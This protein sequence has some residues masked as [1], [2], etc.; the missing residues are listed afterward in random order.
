MLNSTHDVSQQK[1]VTYA[2][3]AENLFN[4]ADDDQDELIG[5]KVPERVKEKMREKDVEMLFGEDENED[6]ND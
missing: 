6:W 2:D 3:R 1:S 4:L 5:A